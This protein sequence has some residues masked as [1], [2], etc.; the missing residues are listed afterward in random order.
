MY[1][2]S[3]INRETQKG[4]Q[5][6]HPFNQHHGGGPLPIK[7]VNAPLYVVT[8]ISDPKRYR[9][10]YHLYRRFEKYIADSGAILYT[11][12]L[13]FQDREFEITHAGNPRHIQVR[14]T[15]EL[16]HKENL[17]NLL[18]QRLPPDWKYVAWIDA[19][20][21]FVRPDWVYETVHLLQHYDIIQMFS[22]AADLDPDFQLLN[23]IRE[24]IINA[25]EQS[26][27]GPISMHSPYGGYGG[28]GAGTKHPGY[29]WA[30]RRSALDLL[31]GLIDWAVV[32]SA[33]W[34]MAAALVGQVHVSLSPSLFSAC[35]VY[36]QWC[37][38]WQD[39][40]IKHL[41]YNVGC[42][43][44]LIMHYWHGKKTDR[45]Y[46]NRW[47]ILVENEFD[48]LVDLKRDWQGVWQ[49]TDHNTR[50]R[51]DIRAYLESRNEDSIDV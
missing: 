10:R 22:Q 28:Y 43:D 29:A 49:L 2:R 8:C 30:A 14:S 48:P 45:K 23:G 46:S 5:L 33:D 18:I 42:M 36:V 20:I 35:P 47:H 31:G 6:F 24:G 13:A 1:K 11:I 34:H 9:S 17:L 32:G 50:L 37:L 40:A 25:W 19:D 27:R 51:D 15:S 12:E 4:F 26:Q 38:D 39:R 44:G 41:R 16:W 7:P 3:H 21:E